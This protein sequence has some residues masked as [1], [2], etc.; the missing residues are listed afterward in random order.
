MIRLHYLLIFAVIPCLSSPEAVHAGGKLQCLNATTCP[1]PDIAVDGTGANQCTIEE[2]L[3]TKGGRWKLSCTNTSAS[4]D[5]VWLYDEAGAKGEKEIGRCVYVGGQNSSGHIRDPGDPKQVLMYWHVVRDGT[6]K[7]RATIHIFDKVLNQGLEIE[8]FHDKD[9]VQWV[10]LERRVFSS[11]ADPTGGGTIPRDVQPALYAVELRL[12]AEPRPFDE[13][14]ELDINWSAYVGAKPP[15]P[16]PV[17]VSGDSVYIEN[18]S[19][20]DIT[21]L[22][23]RYTPAA[24]SGGIELTATTSVTINTGDTLATVVRPVVDE[25][26]YTVQEVG[27]L[28]FYQSV[29]G[30]QQIDDSWADQ[31]DLGDMKGYQSA[32]GTMIVPPRIPAVS[33]WGLMVLVLLVFTVGTIALGRRRAPAT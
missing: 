1:R 27:A 15:R 29:Q 6:D 21:F 20:G 14:A 16:S 4:G 17:L 8:V 9:L 7:N 30:G 23:P 3:D 28:A 24:V 25:M 22:D 33:E 13:N 5:F 26:F 2:F 32:A 19:L 11:L 12:I 31:K 10:E 18:L